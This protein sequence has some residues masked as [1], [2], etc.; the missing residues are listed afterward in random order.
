MKIR[1]AIPADAYAIAEVN[2][3]S[4]KA[5]YADML[6]APF[7]QSLSVNGRVPFWKK[8]LESEETTTFVAEAEES[9]Q[10]FISFGACGNNHAPASEAEILALYA[11][12]EVWGKGVGRELMHAAQ[13]N[14]RSAGFT[15]VSLWVLSRNQRG[16]GFYEAAGFVR[17]TD[18]F[19]QREIGG[20]RID[21]LGYIHTLD[22][23]P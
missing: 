14:V 22:Q 15:D 6:P 9:I 18:A 17:R 16:R 2:V 7:L 11:L 12:P 13:Q 8:V 21:E 23:N 19:R 4:W 5:A 10:A 3:R 1:K 20:A